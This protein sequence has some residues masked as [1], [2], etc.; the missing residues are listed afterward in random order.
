MVN[1]KL[2]SSI[3]YKENKTI[4]SEDLKY[5]TNAY[6]SEILGIPLEFA[7]GKEK[8]TYMSKNIIYYPIYVLKGDVIKSQIGVY[9]IMAESKLGILDEDGDI[10]V[11]KLDSPLLYSFVTEEFIKKAINF[12]EHVVI[13]KVVKEQEYETELEDESK[14][15]EVI[16]DETDVMKPKSGNVHESP[17]PK[18]EGIFIINASVRPLLLS[19]ETEETSDE[20]KKEYRKSSRNKWVEDFFKNNQ[21]NIVETSTNG[22]CF[23]DT[24]RLAFQQIGHETTIHKLRE[25][26]ANELDNESFQEKR[27]LYL[28][29]DSEI[30]DIQKKMESLKETNGVYAKRIKKTSTTRERDE[31]IGSGKKLAAEY[32]ELEQSLKNAKSLQDLYIGYM[33]NIDSLEKYREYIITSSY[34][35]DAWA[36]STLERVLNVKIIILSEHAYRAKDLDGIMNCGE[37]NKKLEHS[38]NFKPNFYI[39]TNYTGN[40]Y[41]LISYKNKRIF[42]FPEIPY[43]IK[44]L[45]INKCLERNSGIF[46]KIQDFR[47]LKSSLGINADEGQPDNDDDYGDHGLYT[48]DVVFM[49]YG[50]SSPAKPGKGTNETIAPEKI[51]E[52]KSLARMED[53]RRKL[54]D[55]WSDAIFTIDRHRWASVEHYIQAAKYK[56]GFPDFYLQFSLDSDSEIS[57]DVAIAKAA[58]ESGKHDGKIWRPKEVKADVD[59]NLGRDVLEREMAIQ[60]KFEQNEDMKQLLKATH[61]ALLNKFVRRGPPLKDVILMKVRGKI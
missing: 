18:K 2:N 58:G 38:E 44:I 45:I 31:L 56:K 24:I 14:V 40:H 59:Y 26:V 27:T 57:K 13:E 15:E 6:D 25:I 39:M 11:S 28:G 33:K 9:E 60:A 8:Y 34:W 17:K 47:N 53:W 48:K 1:S 19:E 12:G 41:E 37:I 54:D 50:K 16:D 36:I 43:D 30:K 52:F 49:F 29:F 3:N 55:T 20:I 23:F 32:A 10:D 42:T 7:L 35:A 5:N 22:D 21:Y 51:N 4:D 46:Y 61:H